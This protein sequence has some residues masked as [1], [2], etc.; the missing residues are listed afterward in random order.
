VAQLIPVRA[1]TSTTAGITPVNPPGLPS[2]G[3]EQAYRGHQ[4]KK[5]MH[6]CAM[7][8]LA[9]DLNPSALIV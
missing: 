3:T 5:T 2:R 8:E 7:A 9:D 4:Q 6:L 1:T